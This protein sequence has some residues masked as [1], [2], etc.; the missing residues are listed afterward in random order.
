M[1]NIGIHTEPAKAQVL[2]KPII[3]D[4]GQECRITIDTFVNA[5]REILY[6]VKWIDYIAN[7]W[8][9][10]FASLALAFARVSVLS[11]CIEFEMANDGDE[12]LG[13]RNGSSVFAE[14]AYRFIDGQVIQLNDFDFIERIEL[15]A[16]SD[17]QRGRFG[18]RKKYT[19][20]RR[21][22]SVIL[23][24]GRENLPE[25]TY[26]EQRKDFDSAELAKAFV[27]EQVYKKMDKGYERAGV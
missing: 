4:L 26:Q 16:R 9:E 21:Y 12:K 18:Y 11:A 3:F 5:D 22:N 23:R 24:W 10:Y 7:E 8:N 19:I 15:V 2:S 20:S 14:Q 1:E 25:Y 17:G 27:V 6:R 13:F